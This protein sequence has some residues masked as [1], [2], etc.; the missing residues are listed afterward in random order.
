ME[1]QRHYRRDPNL[2]LIAIDNAL[3]DFERYIVDI[4]LAITLFIFFI[5]LRYSITFIIINIINI[6]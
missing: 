2:L 6:M 5:I 4:L 3:Y 1:N